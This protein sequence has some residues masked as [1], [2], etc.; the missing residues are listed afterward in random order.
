MIKRPSEVGRG[1]MDSVVGV[2]E[3]FEKMI[4][5]EDGNKKVVIIKFVG[6]SLAILA[7][8]LFYLFYSLSAIDSVKNNLSNY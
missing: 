6:I 5:S 3:K 8:I 4:N 1:G 7:F 2:E